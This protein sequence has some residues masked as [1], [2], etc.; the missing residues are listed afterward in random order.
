MKLK[1][2]VVW[3]YRDTLLDLTYKLVWKKDSLRSVLKI[4]LFVRGGFLVFCVIHINNK[5]IIMER[6]IMKG[7]FSYR[8]W[9]MN[10]L[11]IPIH[12]VHL[13]VYVYI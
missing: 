8:N 7:P 13:Y 12:I 1:F 6:K 9:Y 2:H 10:V 11:N 4:R 3:K 5:S